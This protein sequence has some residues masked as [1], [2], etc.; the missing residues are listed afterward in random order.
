MKELMV[1]NYLRNGNTL[2]DLKNEFAII[3]KEYD[4]GLCILNYSQIDSPKIHQITKECRSLILEKCSWNIVS[5]AFTR[6]FNY[7]ETGGDGINTWDLTP[8]FNYTNCTFTE[9]CDGSLCS[10]FHYNGEWKI[11]TRGSIDNQ[12]YPKMSD[13]T[14][15]ELIINGIMK[16]FESECVTEYDIFKRFDKNYNYIFEITSPKNQIVTQYKKTE[17]TLLGARKVENWNECNDFE[18]KA[19]SNKL[20]IKRPRI[21]EAKNVEELYKSFEK[22]SA[23]FEGAVAVDYSKFNEFGDF[24]RVKIKQQ[25]YLNLHHALDNLGTEHALLGIVIRNETDEVISSF[26]QFKEQL[27]I[28]QKKYSKYVEKQIDATAPVILAK[29]NAKD[30]GEFARYLNSN[31]EIFGD[32]MPMFFGIYDDKYSCWSE[33]L[34]FRIERNG[35]KKVSKQLLEK[36]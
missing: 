25:S 12:T 21:F 22:E 27:D 4:D 6:F 14:F 29:N 2:E 1:Q 16:S 34:D 26:P 36:I 15:N 11:A 28:L 19:L 17:L 7:G 23:D 9:K 3:I 24:Q 30:K 18:L 13:K 10:V 32:E 33:Y 20:N 8:D 35:L 31:K 5:K